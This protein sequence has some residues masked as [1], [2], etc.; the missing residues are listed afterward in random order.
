MS[1]R[2]AVFPRRLLEGA[3]TEIHLIADK[4]KQYLE[5]LLLADEQE[6][7]ID[8]YLE[9]G[10][11]FVL[12]DA[13][14]VRT[15]S[16]VTQESDRIC[17]LKNLATDPNFQHR[18]YGTKM[19]NF[20]CRRYADACDFMYVGTGDSPLTIPFYQSCGFVESHRIPDFFTDNYDHPIWE[21]GRQLVD[22]VYLKRNLRQS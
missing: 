15:V 5:L 22:M 4:K 11:L 6:S 9:R 17:E 13:G 14:I 3:F 7:M 12:S 16:V 18:G 20:L 21:A 2:G 19:V 8:R 1:F 10:N